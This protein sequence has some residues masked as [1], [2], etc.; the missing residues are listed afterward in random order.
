[1][2]S[3]KWVVVPVTAVPATALLGVNCE[4]VHLN[5]LIVNY[6][7]CITIYRYRPNVKPPPRSSWHLR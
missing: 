3:S 6:L 5:L 1:V 7:V 4:S 2:S